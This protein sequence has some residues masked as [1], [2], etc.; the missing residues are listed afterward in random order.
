MLHQ[1]LTRNQDFAASARLAARLIRLGRQLHRPLA[2]ASAAGADAG[3][4]R[5]IAGVLIFTGVLVQAAVDVRPAG[6]VQ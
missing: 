6:R 2:R 4:I 5:S 3:A 1:N